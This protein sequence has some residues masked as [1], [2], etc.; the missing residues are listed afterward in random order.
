MAAFIL[1]FY[2]FFDLSSLL[3]FIEFPNNR[4]I[5]LYI[6]LLM[7]MLYF[8]ETLVVPIVKGML[9]IAFPA[10]AS[11]AAWLHPLIEIAIN[12]S[13]FYILS[14]IVP[15]VLINGMPGA[16]G[17]AILYQ[18]ASMLVSRF[19]SREKKQTT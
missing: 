4:N 5:I 8:I 2:S 6:V 7:I 13:V 1:A 12:A 15:D 3:R 16:L 19:M 17:I 18:L 11:F 14:L 9:R 10:A